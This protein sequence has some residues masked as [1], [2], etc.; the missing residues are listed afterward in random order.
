MIQKAGPK[1]VTRQHYHQQPLQ[2]TATV[3]KRTLTPVTRSLTLGGVWGLVLAST[4]D[5]KELASHG[6]A[7]SHGT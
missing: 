7:D 3:N 5:I 6:P 4:L 1:L 2:A